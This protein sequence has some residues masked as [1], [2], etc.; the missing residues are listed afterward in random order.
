MSHEI[1]RYNNYK[2][3]YEER[4][5]WLIVSMKFSKNWNYNRLEQ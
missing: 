3:L 5:L 4:S 1:N 2:H